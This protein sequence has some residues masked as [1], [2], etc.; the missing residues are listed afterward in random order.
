MG[1][2]KKIKKNTLCASHKN[3]KYLDVTLIKQVKDQYGKK[4]KCL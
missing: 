2:E 4:F 3:I 1:Q